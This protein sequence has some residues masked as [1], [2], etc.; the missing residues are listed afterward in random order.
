MTLSYIICGMLVYSFFVIA[1]LA[2]FFI[3]F[4]LFADGI[5]DLAKE[6]T[7]YDSLFTLKEKDDE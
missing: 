5:T 3:P 4:K 6:E 7:I 2:A 1:I